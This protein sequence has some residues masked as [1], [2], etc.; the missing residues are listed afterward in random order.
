LGGKAMILQAQGK[1]IEAI[2][3]LREELAI[4]PHQESVVQAIKNLLKTSPDI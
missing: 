3:V 1:T 4:N 2:K